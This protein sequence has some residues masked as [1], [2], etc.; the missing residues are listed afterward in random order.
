MSTRNFNKSAEIERKS[1]I[2]YDGFPDLQTCWEQSKI[3]KKYF[4]DYLD[5][6]ELQHYHQQQHGCKPFDYLIA[7]W[8][9][10][11]KLK[12]FSFY[13]IVGKKPDVSAYIEGL[14]AKKSLLRRLSN[15]SLVKKLPNEID[16]LPQRY[17]D[18]PAHFE[19]QA[20]YPIFSKEDRDIILHS[21]E[22]C[23]KRRQMF[24][25]LCVKAC[26][27][28]IDTKNHDTFLLILQILRARIL[29]YIV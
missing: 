23:I 24:R 2:R 15:I 28:K 4:L 7:R 12:F 6:V 1:K 25:N 13:K 16:P 8:A 29:V 22:S 18:W 5:C 10:G 9:D 19:L 14:V 17:E 11:D 3:H 21:I 26:C 27:K 20:V